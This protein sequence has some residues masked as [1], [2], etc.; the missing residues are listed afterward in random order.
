MSLEAGRSSSQG[1]VH[2]RRRAPVPVQEWQCHSREKGDS[3][4]QKKRLMELLNLLDSSSAPNFTIRFLH[5]HFPSPNLSTFPMRRWSRN[6]ASSFHSS[7]ALSSFA[8]GKEIPDTRCSVS[9]APEDLHTDDEFYG[10]T[11]GVREKMGGLQ[12]PKLS[13][14]GAYLILSLSTTN[15]RSQRSLFPTAS[16]STIP[17][18]PA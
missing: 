16:T 17:L 9:E 14:D 3:G 10:R 8:V 15:I 5:T 13:S 1:S 6:S 12:V 11:Q 4:T 18:S 7:Q 2:G